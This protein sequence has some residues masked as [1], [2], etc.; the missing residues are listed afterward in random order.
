LPGIRAQWSRRNVLPLLSPLAGAW[1][2]PPQGSLPDRRSHD[3]PRA[4]DPRLRPRRTWNFLKALYRPTDSRAAAGQSTPHSMRAAAV[5][6]GGLKGLPD[7]PV[8]L[9]GL[10]LFRQRSCFIAVLRFHL[11][12]QNHTPQARWVSPSAPRCKTPARSGGSCRACGQ[13]FVIG[14]YTPAQGA[15]M[16]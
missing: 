14:G 5:S 7:W 12:P 8:P 10:S 15:S 13:E 6:S 1:P 4:L 3:S 11:C 2:M 16:L 9:V